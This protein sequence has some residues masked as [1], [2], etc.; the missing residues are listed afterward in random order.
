MPMLQVNFLLFAVAENDQFGR[1]S[2]ALATQL[3][4]IPLFL[5]FVS[6]TVPSIG[7]FF[8]TD[9]LPCKETS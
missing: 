1:D 8:M 3:S 2:G 6:G 4:N 7:I 9:V 5:P